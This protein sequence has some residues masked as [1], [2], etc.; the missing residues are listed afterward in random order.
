[1]SAVAAAIMEQ[2]S[3]NTT[4]WLSNGSKEVTGRFAGLERHPLGLN[5]KT[6]GGDVL[7]RT[8]K[9]VADECMAECDRLWNALADGM[10]ALAE[11]NAAA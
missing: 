4:H 8:S 9:A 10:A 7:F 3:I 1:M 6:E 5:I 2:M 11:Y